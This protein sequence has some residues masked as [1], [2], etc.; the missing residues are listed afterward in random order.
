ML[1]RP[2]RVGG[3]GSWNSWLRSRLHASV[4]FLSTTPSPNPFLPPQNPYPTLPPPA[5]ASAVRRGLGLQGPRRQLRGRE[6][7]KATRMGETG[8][9]V[10]T[11]FRGPRGS[12]KSNYY[13]F[14]QLRQSAGWGREREIPH[15]LPLPPT[16]PTPTRCHSLRSWAPLGGTGETPAPGS[17]A[18]R[19]CQSVGKRWGNVT[20]S[21]AV[22]GGACR[23]KWRRP[24][25]RRDRPEV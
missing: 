5:P 6:K 1:H 16:P 22:V 13:F 7:A 3:R 17:A 14:G 24:A 19:G 12:L 18:L 9:L 20:F 2:A 8:F 10:A 11:G 25:S 21:P 15:P 4:F 23:R